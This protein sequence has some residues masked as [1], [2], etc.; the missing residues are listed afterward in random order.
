M[1]PH[2]N[3]GRK[4]MKNIL[5]FGL[6]T[7]FV[8][9][10]LF[11][12]GIH[13]F[14][15]TVALAATTTITLNN[16]GATIEDVST[17][18]IVDGQVCTDE[19]C[20]TTITTNKGMVTPKKQYT[21]TYNVNADDA[22]VSP[23]SATAA[24]TFNGYTVTYKNQ[25]FTVIDKN[26]RLTSDYR[27]MAYDTPTAQWTGTPS[28]RL[29]MPTR[30]GYTFNGWNTKSDGTGTPYN[31]GASYTPTASTILYAQWEP[32]EC[33]NF[34]LYSANGA[35]NYKEYDVS[36]WSND[37][38]T[39]YDGKNCPDG[40]DLTAIDVFIGSL[41]NAD[42][43]VPPIFCDNAALL[44][45]S[46][47]DEYMGLT[48]KCKVLE[49]DIWRQKTKCADG[50]SG[51]NGNNYA[52]AGEACS[53]TVYTI[54]YYAPDNSLLETKTYSPSTTET[55]PTQFDTYTV[56]KWEEN[57]NFG[58]E[59][60][61]GPFDP[62]APVSNVISGF[63]GCG[64][65]SIKLIAQ[66]EDVAT[67]PTITLINTGATTA[68]IDSLYYNE[69]RFYTDAK[70]R[71]EISASA[72]MTIPVRKYKVTYDAQSGT[73]SPTSASAQYT[74]D[75]YTVTIKGVEYQ[76]I[77]SDGKLVS[78]NK[79][80]LLQA[81]QQGL[82]AT[83][84]WTGTPSVKLPMPTRSGYTF[85]GW[86]KAAQIVDIVGTAGDPY[87]TNK[88]ITLYAL[89]DEC[90]ACNAGTGATCSFAGV[91]DNTCAYTTTCKTGY[92]NIQNSGKYNPSCT[93][94]TYT[95]TLDSKYYASSSATNGTN[96]SSWPYPD[97]IYEHYNNGWYEDDGLSMDFTSLTELPIYETYVF[98]GFFTGKA[99]T[100]TQVIAS[101]GR[102]IAPNFLFDKDTTI[103]AHYISCTCNSNDESVSSCSAKGTSSNN[104]N[105]CYYTVTCAD[106]YSDN[107]F[108]DGKRTFTETGNKPGVP[109][110]TPTCKKIG[111]TTGYICPAD[112]TR[113]ISC[114][115]G[116]YMATLDA[117]GNY[118]YNGKPTSDNSCQPC[119]DDAAYCP[120]DTSAPLYTVTLND[121]LDE[122]MVGTLYAN[123]NAEYYKDLVQDEET[124]NLTAT[125]L[126]GT[127]PAEFIPTAPVGKTFNGYWTEGG[128]Q[129]IDA[130]G[131][132]LKGP[133]ADV[134][135]HAQWEANQ[136]IISYACGNGS[137]TAPSQIT[138]DVGT[139]CL[140]AN[141]T[142]AAPKGY[143][144][145]GWKI[146]DTVYDNFTDIRSKLSA[147]TYTATAQYEKIEPEFTM[148]VYPISI[149][150]GNT[151]VFGL[152][153]VQGTFLFDC[154]NGESFAFF[155]SDDTS[156]I[157]PACAY[158]KYKQEYEIKIASVDD[159]T[160]TK[161][162]SGTFKTRTSDD[163][164][165]TTNSL[166]TKLDGSLGKLFNNNNLSIGFASAFSNATKLTY[167]SP[168][169]LDG[170]S[171]LY[172]VT[173]MFCTNTS[174]TN[175][176]LN[177]LTPKEGCITY[178]SS[179]GATEMFSGSTKLSS[180]TDCDGNVTDYL[181]ASL[182][183]RLNSCETAGAFKRAFSGTA[184]A[185][186]CPAGTYEVGK[187][188]N[189]PACAPCPANSS[190]EAGA[191]SCTCN[192]GY[193]YNGGTTTTTEACV[194]NCHDV[195][196]WRYYDNNELVLYVNKNEQ[197]Q[198][199]YDSQCNI[200]ATLDVKSL[201]GDMP[202][203][204]E[205]VDYSVDGVTC[206]NANGT[207]TGN[208]VVTETGTE[209]YPTYKCPAGHHG[210]EGEYTGYD[211]PCDPDCYQIEFT[212]YD[213]DE[214]SE[215]S[216][217]YYM[218]PGEYDRL[219]VDDCY[220]GEPA[221]TTN[222]FDMLLHS[223]P[224][225]V[226]KGYYGYSDTESDVLCMDA[227][228]E[229]TGNCDDTIFPYWYA[230][231]QCNPGF[232]GYG[233]IV[234]SDELCTDCYSV[235]IYPAETVMNQDY[236]FVNSNDFYYDYC[237]GG[238]S[239]QGLSAP[240][241]DNAISMGY[242]QVGGYDLSEITE[243]E[244]MGIL[245]TSD[246][247]NTQG[248]LTGN[249]DIDSGT[250][251]VAVYKCN[252]GYTAN[253]TF[254]DYDTP[255]SANVY[256][257]NITYDCGEYAAGQAPESP[258]RC[259][260]NDDCIMPSADAC[261]VYP[262]HTFKEWKFEREGG[263]E[264]T[265]VPG[266]NVQSYI[267]G[268]EN[269]ATWLVV[270]QWS[271]ACNPLE[272]CYTPV[273][274][275]SCATY[276]MRTG[277]NTQIYADNI[278]DK[279]TYI[280]QEHLGYVIN[281]IPL[282]LFDS[283]TEEQCL[284]QNGYL[285]GNCSVT[286]N[287]SWIAKYECEDG[288]TGIGS[289]V[290]SGDTCLPDCIEI[291]LGYS[292]NGDGG[293][294][295]YS[296]YMKPGEYGYLYDGNCYTTKD[297]LDTVETEYF[298]YDNHGTFVGFYMHDDNSDEI[299]QCTDSNG[300]ILG[301]CENTV[302]NN[303][304]WW[305]RYRC[306]TGYTANGDVIEAGDYEPCSNC[307]ELGII[308]S[309]DYINT[310]V[311]YIQN[312]GSLYIDSVC[313]NSVQGDALE[314]KE[315]PANAKF[316]G[317]TN[318][319]LPDVSYTGELADDFLCT[320]SDMN[321]QLGL[322]GNCT[323]SDNDQVW[324]A[325]YECAEG[326]RANGKF[327]DY[328]MSCQPIQF[329]VYY[330]SGN[331]AEGFDIAEAPTVITC[332]YG[333]DCIVGKDV[334]Y[335]LDSAYKMKWVSGNGSEYQ[336]GDNIKNIITENGGIYNLDAETEPRKVN[337]DYNICEN[338]GECSETISLGT[339]ELNK[340]CYIGCSDVTQN[341]GTSDL[342]PVGY[343]VT[344]IE[345]NGDSIDD[346]TMDIFNGVE[347]I[348]GHLASFHAGQDYEILLDIYVEPNKYT[349]V[350]DANGGAGTMADQTFKYDAAQNLTANAFTY[351]GY[352]FAGWNT[353]ANGSG[354]AYADKAPIS[355]LLNNITLYAQWSQ[356]TFT[357]KYYDGA[358]ELTNLTPTTYN[359]TSSTITL[360]T[361]TKT[362]HTFGGW[363]D[364]S[365]LTGTA[366]TQIATGST[367][368]K[369]F[370]AKWTIMSDGCVA[371]EYLAQGKTACEPC[372]VG[373]YCAGGTF[374][375]DSTKDQG[376]NACSGATQYQNQSGQATCKTVSDGYYKK[377]NTAQTECGNG[378][379]CKNAVRT[380]CPNGYVT[381]TTTA[382]LES[383]CY[384]ACTVACTE[385]TC[386]K[387]AKCTHGTTTTN[388]KQYVGSTCNAASSTCDITI[389]CNNG[390]DLDGS[391]CVLHEYT[392]TYNLNGGE[393]VG[394][395]PKTYTI[396]TPT[397]YLP[398]PVK[399]G[400]VFGGWHSPAPISQI[401]EGSTGN[402]EITA[403]WTPIEYDITFDANDGTGSM[404]T[405][406]FTYGV[407]QNLTA[408]AF[409][410]DGYAFTGWNTASDGSGTA[411][412]DKAPISNLLNNITLYAQWSQSTFTI[413]YYDGATELTNLTPTTYNV[414]S[415]TITLPTPTKTGHTFG[416]WYDN[417][418]LTG[419]AVTQIATGSTGNKT[420]WAKWT[421][422]SDGCVAGEYLAQG[423]T[424]CEPCKVGN[425]C[426]GGTFNYD[427]TKDQGIN[428]C[429]GATQYQNQSG[430]A[431]CKTVSDGYYKKDNTAQ[432][433]CGNGYYCKNA[434]RTVCPDNG[435][436]DTAT[437]SDVTDCYKNNQSCT[438]NGG[439]GI[440]DVCHYDTTKSGYKNCDVCIINGC[441][442]GYYKDN[443]TCTICP[444]GSYC[445]NSDKNACPDN[446][447]TAGTGA[448]Q[449]KDCFTTCDDMAVEYGIA[450]ADNATVSAP[451]ECSYSRGESVTGNP[452][453]IKNGKCVETSCKYNYEM[454]GGQ[455]TECVRDNA[456]TFK[457]G[458]GNCVV[459][460]CEFGYYPD[461]AGQKC[462]PAT[463]ECTMLSMHAIAA[464]QTW[465]TKT[466]SYTVCQIT[467]CA[468]GYH[469][470]NNTCI[471][472][473]QTCNVPNGIGGVQ[474][475]NGSKWGECVATKCKPGYT[476]D[477]DLMWPAHA[478]DISIQCG[479]C[480]NAFDTNGAEAAH[481]YVRECEIA[482]CMYQGKK[483]IL[484]NNECRLICNA[485][486]DETGSRYWDS[487]SEECVHTCNAGYQEW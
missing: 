188:G 479:R 237:E 394:E 374:N 141:S 81:M 425:Y 319:E 227:N 173:T 216:Q 257:V 181:P 358:T 147:G 135:L 235:N 37:P 445:A 12:F 424:A 335:T 379:Y 467:E 311:V 395:Y 1:H 68:R 160:I 106:E 457:Q 64:G 415:S 369:T 439:F 352:T 200:P 451:L 348:R 82:P 114:Y 370:W 148:T 49:G 127:L 250:R 347:D 45:C 7:R 267:E 462:M 413:K 275:E 350:F 89:W 471:S 177:L 229:L 74:F 455:C 78:A 440:S 295:F 251:W 158:S 204:S 441:S 52:L 300:Q 342:V 393:L 133:S 292:E 18:Y 453:D 351:T 112:S 36:Q 297:R 273:E 60:G 373:N 306:D 91:S 402:I 403:S 146:D 241:K 165:K 454:K 62:G 405:Q 10:F 40:T 400:H 385:Q 308:P 69:N 247:R 470:S 240:Q 434:V 327:V 170:F 366:V 234:G 480:D 355:N 312:N 416:G 459:E 270:A 381:D 17:L 317:Y 283:E 38:Y 80:Y 354:T 407:A 422:M 228:G 483:Y 174:L 298:G 349:V 450:H 387:N 156:S 338:T 309:A 449:Q 463:K 330:D 344:S 337:I 469:I 316:L 332:T 217:L 313:Q 179:L 466:N 199:Y 27:Q 341:C 34:V 119:P 175:I 291:E 20:R 115:T 2:H 30:S 412:A 447:T 282:G 136:Y 321:Y 43:S 256:T 315:T 378:Y 399:E 372:K 481:T 280:E 23:E 66:W 13:A 76:V 70:F 293:D 238:Q 58:G 432:T 113:Y 101:D 6:L 478:K 401:V 281:G 263:D 318:M 448:T 11:I 31:A 126:E 153:G 286:P 205:F 427:S 123:V 252:D 243:E 155:A 71:S 236:I 436:T 4:H 44:E 446:Y 404:A 95:I 363:Y 248:G 426:A 452:C 376:I 477:R 271:P 377:D 29:P 213:T 93:A 178:V 185:D 98:A 14:T 193:N 103:F 99:G 419:T 143:M 96:V 326:Y 120:G 138:C 132:F 468:D 124:G 429:S 320:S 356:S 418:G 77:N 191:T 296:Y 284:T 423:K 134:T 253:G 336:T 331:S 182:Y 39:L 346:A 108:D 192:D 386:P 391:T 164:T 437:A 154:G 16:N 203:G 305:A 343:K 259:S 109:N 162:S 414:T 8:M 166:I 202:D 397:F 230:Y 383:E 456:R 79:R 307:Y 214:G 260:S 384:T 433:E 244:L 107:G 110:Y 88:N 144:F 310:D 278:C 304:T 105:A 100:G 410:R 223:R 211:V 232:T 33:I 288:Y 362:G 421:I 210:E 180:V 72:A 329:D 189:K 486:D 482:T 104:D 464:Q 118:E 272:V 139:K 183:E 131:N 443:N 176:P 314:P 323:V 137:G 396:V 361:P 47:E 51:P 194:L 473:E 262:G 187:I 435:L 207:L 269:D 420:F 152:N 390:Y 476:N 299:V 201:M 3:W 190:S 365:G 219:Y 458:N 94:N 84:K 277:D 417:S 215:S 328:D 302:K 46:N 85:T 382:S 122:S 87:T 290:W 465:D 22:S 130:N 145:S 129:Y 276:Y 289:E 163:I 266:Q 221:E 265:V 53:E 285:T 197:T 15:P 184:L 59:C 196:L 254:V 322:T 161:S 222:S 5:K 226:L 56:T 50:F 487:K 408:N 19:R 388:G 116:K 157:T 444:Q 268:P 333:Q 231:Y 169:L 409:T 274:G 406:T 142:C 212:Y 21:V 206:I 460:S 65:Y 73:V 485:K 368:N 242:A 249:C 380:Q 63:D 324:T 428:A 224:N 472:D 233:D 360:P 255:C 367:G 294:S 411:Y 83:V 246:D 57:P 220:S 392:I 28:V 340:P 484:E 121:D 334:D 32:V 359:V 54:E 287:S 117:L 279:E 25:T 55:L 149:L 245:C 195:T 168:T 128:E 209:W 357:I 140:L 35:N 26:G 41:P 42:N 97:K 90:D 264:I 389:S 431:T 186:T 172:S 371:G 75:G 398:T 353:A 375:Y 111:L 151:Q 339:C 461:S 150:T 48:G 475:W 258:K 442:S 171:N 86:S 345:I 430:Q 67:A 9:L 102:I 167:I 438:V 364:N 125:R 198:F 303:G 225:S 474:T 239:I 325:V 24:Y 159:P 261:G 218:K 61:F 92:S 301:D 208:C